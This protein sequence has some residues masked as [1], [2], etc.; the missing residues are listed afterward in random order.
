MVRNFFSYVFAL[1]LMAADY[2][3]I[4]AAFAAAYII[5]VDIDGRQLI[6]DIQGWEFMLI[7][8]VL[9]PLWIAVFA[10]LGLYRQDVYR[11]KLRE[12][13]LLVIGSAVGMLL[14]IAYDFANLDTIFPARRVPIYAAF[15]TVIFLWIGRWVMSIIR[16]RLFRVGY[17]VAN[18][19]VIG[20]THMTTEVIRQLRRTEH[21]GHRI[22]AAMSNTKWLRE[23]SG[24]NIAR[25]TNLTEALEFM[26]SGKVNVVIQ[27]ERYSDPKKN[28][29]IINTA[30]SNHI[31]YKFVP[32]EDGILSSN[33]Q[34]DLLA[35]IP[36]VS[37]YPTALIGWGRI[38]KRAYDIVLAVV[39]LIASLPIWFVVALVIRFTDPKGP[40]LYMHKRVTRYGK[41]IKVYKLRSMYWEYCAGKKTEEQIF[42]EMGRKDLLAEWKENQKVDNDPRIMPIGRLIRKYSLDELP[43]LWNVLLG[44]LS[45]IGPRA[46]TKKELDRYAKSSPLFLS[47]KP[48]VTGLWQVSG[49]NEDTYDERIALDL[50]YVRN[51]SFLLDLKI[52][53]LTIGAVLKG[54]G[55]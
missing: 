28:Q 43:Q 8:A 5:R 15:L 2:V 1:V 22:V 10:A 7:M 42:A 52:T 11:R 27:T 50:Y 49:R 47:I 29:K 4:M 3:A 13:M 35:G 53:Y 20:N 9:L 37:A 55:K 36:V 39:G 51:W 26:G 31:G 38:L 30:H 44:D 25:M 46:V 34:V 40:V 41:T 12:L 14:V 19:L 54:S 18:V 6:R 16:R 17:G 45:L 48:G 33:L 32:H 21:T 24:M 23:F